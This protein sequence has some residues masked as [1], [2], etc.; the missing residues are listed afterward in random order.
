MLRYCMENDK[1]PNETVDYKLFEIWIFE[2]YEYGF[3]SNSYTGPFSLI[4]S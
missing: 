2:S 1:W 4:L 3:G